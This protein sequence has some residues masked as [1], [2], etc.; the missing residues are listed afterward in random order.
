[1]SEEQGRLM[2]MPIIPGKM[3]G[4]AVIEPILTGLAVRGQG[5]TSILRWLRENGMAELSCESQ[6]SPG[7]IRALS[8][9]KSRL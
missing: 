9:D 3:L 5:G 8:T 4:I 2:K 1:M 7:A 6:N